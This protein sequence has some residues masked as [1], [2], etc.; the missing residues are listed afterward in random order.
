[1]DFGLFLYLG[2]VM[3]NEHSCVSFM[4]TYVFSGLDLGAEL[5]GRMMTSEETGGCFLKWLHHLRSEKLLY[6]LCWP[7]SD[8][9]SLFELQTQFHAEPQRS[10]QLEL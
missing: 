1:M 5:L 6:C 3:D 8:A 4:W 7:I 2:S 9:G 10:I